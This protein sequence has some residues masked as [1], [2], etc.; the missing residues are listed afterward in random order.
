MIEERRE[1]SSNDKME[2][3]ESDFKKPI[4]FVRNSEIDITTSGQEE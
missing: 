3:V 4:T 2:G 1:S